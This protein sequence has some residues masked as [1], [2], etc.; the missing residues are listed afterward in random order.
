MIT[1]FQG[2]GSTVRHASGRYLMI[3]EYAASDA[4]GFHTGEI[5]RE[6]R[7]MDHPLDGWRL[8]CPPDRMRSHL[9]RALLD[10]S[11]DGLRDQFETLPA[12]GCACCG[13]Y[14]KFD[15]TWRCT[16][17]TVRCEK[18]AKRNPCAIEGCKRTTAARQ[19]WYSNDDWLC[20]THWRIACPP[21]SALRRA[22]HRLFRLKK[23]I[24][25][26]TPELNARYWRLMR[27]IISRARGRDC[28]AEDLAAEVAK[29]MG[30]AA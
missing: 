23:K 1:K 14:N 18:H 7:L 19:G 29:A 17:G 13:A 28:G 27:G 22:Y 21:R 25:R 2:Q 6:Y 5:I 8:Y 4:H 12:P 15:R 26:S 24:G 3:W 10:P 20:G 9:D 11:W 30:W 16:D